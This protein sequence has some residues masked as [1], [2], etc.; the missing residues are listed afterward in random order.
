MNR[1]LGILFIIVLCTGCTNQIQENQPKGA[2]TQFSAQVEE[3]PKLQQNLGKKE[4]KVK[5]KPQWNK[6]KIVSEKKKLGVCYAYPSQDGNSCWLIKYE[7]DKNANIEIVQIPSTIQGMKVTKVGPKLRENYVDTIFGVSVWEDGD[8]LIQSKKTEFLGKI[9]K[10]VFGDSIEIIGE[11]C[12]SGLKKLECIVLP[13]SLRQITPYAR[14]S[15]H[16]QKLEL[17]KDNSYFILQDGMLI[18]NKNKQILFMLTQKKEVKIPQNVEKLGAFYI[19]SGIEKIYIPVNVKQ[20]ENYA[21]DST[22][23]VK[24]VVDSQ[25][26]KYTSKKTC[27]YEKDT[28]R[29]LAIT[30]KNKTLTIV[31]GV[32]RIDEGVTILGSGENLANAQINKIIYPKSIKVVSSELM[33]FGVPEIVYLGD[34]PWSV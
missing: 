12:L 30:L 28:G 23:E 5:K 34:K 7:L 9:K 33:P 22:K 8:E 32:K 1:I 20:I 2:K 13:K 26:T 4:E 6:E 16:I 24:V 21:F 25:H 19:R 14:Y 10:L 29:L 27:V 11:D 15:N 3:T 31:E 17:S 18:R